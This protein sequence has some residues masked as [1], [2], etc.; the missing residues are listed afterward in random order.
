[1]CVLQ[2]K[3]VRL[4]AL[5]ALVLLAACSTTEIVGSW[6]D[7]QFGQAVGSMLVIARVEDESLR[8][9]FE[10]RFAT[11]LQ[12]QGVN[13]VASYRVF[14]T[15]AELDREEVEQKARKLHLQGVLI[16]RLLGVEKVEIQQPAYSAYGHPYG[17]PFGRW[18]DYYRSWHSYYG[19][20]YGYP[21]APTWTREATLLRLETNLYDPVGDR[22]VWSAR[23]ETTTFVSVEEKIEEVVRELI[24]QLERDALF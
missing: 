16:S 20:G 9:M 7:P 14:P 24:R 22:L 19:Y 12:D 23:S 6:K 2:L 13:A 3:M 17:D 4:A 5:L 15:V 18:P 1:M 8:R 11:A 10:D 21:Y